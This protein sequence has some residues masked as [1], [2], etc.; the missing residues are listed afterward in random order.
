MRSLGWGGRCRGI[1]RRYRPLFRLPPRR[2]IR[3]SR[4]AV[5]TECQ[6]AVAGP[7]LA[8]NIFSPSALHSPRNADFDNQV[9]NFDQT[10]KLL[11]CILYGGEHWQT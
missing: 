4:L 9:S 3:R 6:A 11:A 2:A 8:G 1:K 7:I 5:A 10:A